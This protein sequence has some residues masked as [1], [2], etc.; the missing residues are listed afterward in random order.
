VAY[1]HQLEEAN[2]NLRQSNLSRLKSQ[3]FDVVVVGGG[4]NGAVSAACLA[5]RGLSVALIDRGDF[6]GE[7]SQHSSNLAWGG[8]KYLE[9]YEF[10]LVKKLCTSRNHLI[11][12]YPSSVKEIRFFVTHEKSFRHGRLKLFLGSL[13]YWLMGGF[14]TRAPRLLS[15]QTIAKEQP[16]IALDGADGGFE[17]S[18][19]FL[20]DNDARF[21]WGF[22]RSALDHGA[23][24]VNYVESEKPTYVDGAWKLTLKDVLSGETFETKTKV[25]INACGPYVD[26]HNGRTG[27]ST[28]HQHVFSKGIH[29]IVPRI[30]GNDRVLTF[31]ADDGR[32]FFVIPMGARTCIGTTDTKVEDP[33]TEVTPEDRTFVLSNI[34]KRLRLEKPLTEDDVIAERCGVRPLASS[35]KKSGSSDWMQMSRK[36]AVDVDK[37]QKHISIF[38]GKLTDCINVGEEIASL[39]SELGVPPPYPDRLWYGEPQAEVRER[40]FHL[41]NLMQLD[42]LTAGAS[43]EALSTRLWRRYGFSAFNMLEAIRID[44]SQADL[45]LGGAEYTRCE[46]EHAARNEMVTKLSDFLRRRSKIALVMKKEEIFDAPGLLE[47]ARTFFGEAAEERIEEYFGKRLPHTS[48]A[49]H[50]TREVAAAE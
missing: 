10:G 12:S 13:L 27:V 22:V 43:S 14:F 40:F 4:I 45:L 31:F 5:A 7:T 50:S 6:A 32:L 21:V 3:S 23:I 46:I 30:S 20:H 25:L 39:V 9:S 47:A 16:R 41:A 35:K 1:W 38:G 24:G 48:K 8:I 37:A 18:D 15:K 29:L 19:A 33:R 44:P 36:H 2:L 11:A 26:E 34:N 42:T 28:E 17:Y 49:R